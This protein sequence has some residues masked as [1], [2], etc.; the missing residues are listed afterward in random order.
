[1]LKRFRRELIGLLHAI[2]HPDSGELRDSLS[3]AAR[4]I[5]K[6]KSE[7]NTPRP[8][9][10]ILPFS[11]TACSSKGQLARTIILNQCLISIR[12]FDW[13][14]SPNRTFNTMALHSQEGEPRCINCFNC[15]VCS[16]FPHPTISADGVF[17]RALDNRPNR[18][19][20][21]RRPACRNR[22]RRAFR[23][24]RCASLC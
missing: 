15:V 12:R 19:K 21:F 11:M 14:S 9:A 4:L 5:E 20:Q 2:R 7:A 3:K 1:M 16:Q 23:L 18:L 17:A 6:I 13:V 8:N 10:K 24:Y 22:W